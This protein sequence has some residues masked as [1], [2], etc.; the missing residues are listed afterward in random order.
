M[1]GKLDKPLDEIVSAQRRTAG[2]RRSQRRPAGRAAVAAPVGG[3]Q[4]AT[5]ATRGAA[6]KAAP[7]KSA[8]LNG[9]SK[10]IVSNLVS[11]SCSVTLEAQKLT[12]S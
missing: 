12:S 8:A 4:K 9:E 11:V 3:I 5:K 10:V 1:S 6:A 7:A 2:R